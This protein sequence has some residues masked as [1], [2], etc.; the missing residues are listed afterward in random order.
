MNKKV[1][2]VCILVCA[3]VF[4]CL[5]GCS[6]D[7]EAAAASSGTTATASS[8]VNSGNIPV[9]PEYETFKVEY[10]SL[11]NI[12][13][14]D[15]V[16]R[17]GKTYQLYYN[18]SG[19]EINWVHVQ[20]NDFVEKG[21]VLVE[22][23]TSELEKMLELKR[24]L[25][26]KVLLKMEELQEKA[27]IDGFYDEY[28]VK[29]ASL[30]LETIDVDIAGIQEKISD[31]VIVSPVSGTVHFIDAQ[32]GDI[33]Q[34]YRPFIE[35]AMESGVQFLADPV[36]I[37]D[38]YDR[39]AV[40]ELVFPAGLEKG[41]Q[42]VIRYGSGN[43]N[44]KEIKCT[45]QSI[46]FPLVEANSIEGETAFDYRRQGHYGL[47]S[48]ISVQAELDE[49]ISVDLSDDMEAVMFLDT[50]IERKA[51]VVPADCINDTFNER[52]V[53]V[54]ERVKVTE[55]FVRTGIWDEEKNVVEI[56]E[57]LSE[58]ELVVIDP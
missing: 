48:R 45:V 18:V 20:I 44:M 6:S 34:V 32:E 25:R 4:F 31:C 16:L 39:N 21:D 49:N 23:D 37:T 14:L 53:Y 33:S 30:E 56:L 8:G 1:N 17:H 43:E 26:K 19:L 41:M 50:G 38:V 10:Q 12:I 42:G 9:Q 40:N 7:L 13:R 52:M 22:L 28:S 46:R 55:R 2:A 3:A 47:F 36:T 27:D 24:M 29:S 57:G 51:L 58:G 54:L 15:G 5:S 11:K 35:I